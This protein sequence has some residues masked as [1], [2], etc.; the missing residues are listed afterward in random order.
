MPPFE[1]LVLV[2]VGLWLG[3]TTTVWSLLYAEGSR[4]ELESEE[5]VG[6]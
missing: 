5:L 6:K 2:G 3:V 4:A 1:P